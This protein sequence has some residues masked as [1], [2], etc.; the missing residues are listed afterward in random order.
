MLFLL[1]RTLPAVT[2]LAAHKSQLPLARG[3]PSMAPHPGSQLSATGTAIMHHASSCTV[4]RIQRH[5]PPTRP[6]NDPDNL[7]G[8]LELFQ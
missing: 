5:V 8:P 2:Q 7:D 4:L 1:N 3:D 6:P